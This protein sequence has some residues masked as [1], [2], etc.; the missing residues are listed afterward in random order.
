MATD[1]ACIAVVALF[2]GAYPLVART[3]NFGGPLGTLVLSLAG[4]VPIV[5]AAIWGG[6]ALRPST[7]Q[8]VRLGVAGLMMGIG[9][10]AFNRLANG[11]LD[12]SVSIPIVDGAMLVATT[13]GALWFFGEPV[14]AQKLAGIGLL[15]AG[16]ALLRPA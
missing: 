13:V 9:L 3:S 5:L 10:I 4:L 7:N 16:I 8:L 15:L 11:T 2:W 14:T 12:A 6:F 1:V